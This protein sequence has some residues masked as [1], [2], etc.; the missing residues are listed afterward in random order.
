MGKAG[1]NIRSALFLAAVCGQ[2]Y[3]QFNH[4]EGWFLVPKGYSAVGTFDGKAY[5][6][7][8]ERFGFIIESDNSFIAAFRGTGSAEDWASDLIADQTDYFPV[9]GAGLTHRG[10][11]DIYKSIRETLLGQLARLPA[12]KP[13]FITGHSLGGALATLAALDI[14]A[15]TGFRNPKVYTFAAPRVGNPAFVKKYNKTIACHYRIQNEF[16]MI[17]H[18]PP[19][20]YSSPR[21]N[22]KSYY[23]HVRGKVKRSFQTGT[24]SGNHVLGNYFS[25][26]AKDDP[27]FA[28]ALCAYPPGWCPGV[29]SGARRTGMRG[30]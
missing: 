22:Q 2:T 1:L 27:A 19:L 30:R 13:L 9:K 18:L 7:T 23:M 16:D 3:S 6:G 24:I 14:S 29:R 20:V 28:A 10:F 26:L 12:N 21:T 11:T 17:P 15:N 8:R 5:A 25:D 4:P